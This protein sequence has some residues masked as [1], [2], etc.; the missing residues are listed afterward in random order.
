MAPTLYFLVDT[1]LGSLQ[2]NTVVDPKIIQSSP[3]A[4][5]VWLVQWILPC[6]LLHSAFN[7]ISLGTNTTSIPAVL[8]MQFRRP[9]VRCGD[10][11]ALNTVQRLQYIRLSIQIQFEDASAINLTFVLHLFCIAPRSIFDWCNILIYLFSII[12]CIIGITQ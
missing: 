1:T 8:Q 10:V 9:Q 5:V 12:I 6:K 3:I 4:N 7:S 11:A 2:Y